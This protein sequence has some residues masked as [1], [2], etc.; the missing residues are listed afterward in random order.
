[1]FTKIRTLLTRSGFPGVWQVRTQIGT[2]RA[3]DPCYMVVDDYGT[4]VTPRI[5]QTLYCFR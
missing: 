3:G 1:M 5:T 2:E 4:L